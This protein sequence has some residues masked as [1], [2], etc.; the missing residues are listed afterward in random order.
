MST[1]CCAWPPNPQAEA[2]EEEEEIEEEFEDE[3]EAVPSSVRC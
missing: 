3:E 1:P 2:A